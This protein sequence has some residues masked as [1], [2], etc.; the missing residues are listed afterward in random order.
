MSGPVRLE[1]EG[2]LAVVTLAAPPL[3]LFDEAMFAGVEA[4]LDEL[5][6]DPPRGLLYDARTLERWN[7]VNRVLDDDGFDAAARAFAMRLASWP[8]RAHAATKQIVR[9]AL[10]G[11][12]EGADRIVPVLA[13]ELFD[14]RDLREAVRSFLEEGPGR[15][16]YEGR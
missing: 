1:R 15:V 9:A 4:A 13:G 8:T 10:E 12:V 16:A 7:V 5:E 11:G 14:T 2:P 6:A 3:N